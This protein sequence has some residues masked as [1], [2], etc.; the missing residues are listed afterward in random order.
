VSS[1]PLPRSPRPAPS[2]EGAVFASVQPEAARR[3]L[4]A[5]HEVFA[6]RGY[7]GAS[8]REIAAAAAMSPAAMYI[9]Y[10]SKQDLLF[11]LSL[12]GHEACEQVVR[13]AAEAAARSGADASARLSTVAGAFARWHAEHH[14]TAR[15]VHYELAS[16]TRDNFEAVAAVRRRIDA[17]FRSIVQDGIADGQFAI[18]DLAATTLALESLCV[19]VGR[20]FP[21]GPFHSPA[22]VERLY[23]DLALRLVRA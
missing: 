7:A 13:I 9:H 12:L 11:H 19:D 18:A 17:V 10:R 1:E 14:A 16:L 5:G 6:A 21:S 15:I 23:A 2:I 20:W 3:L 22:D 4:L 8:T